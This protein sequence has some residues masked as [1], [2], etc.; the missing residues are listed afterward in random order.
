LATKASFG[1]A[2]RSRGLCA[3]H[4]FIAGLILAS[5]TIPGGGSGAA[6]LK[7]VGSGEAAGQDDPIPAK[8]IVRQDGLGDQK[9]LL[10]MMKGPAA[11]I[12]VDLDR[13]QRLRSIAG[14]MGA[15]GGDMRGFVGGTGTASLFGF[16]DLTVNYAADEDGG[17]AV[18]TRFS[19]PIDDFR[20]TFSH[21]FNRD[22]ESSWTGSGDHRAKRIYEGWVDWAGLPELPLGLGIR[23]TSHADGSYSID[24]RAMQTIPI[25]ATGGSF[26]NTIS[27][28][29]LQDQSSITN[30]TL[31]YY[32]PI[33]GVYASAE[34]DYT[35]DKG[36]DVTAARF[37]I[38]KTFEDGWTLFMY[39]NQPL[40]VGVGRLDFGATRDLGGFTVS[41]SASAG[42]DGS[43]Y[44]GL[45]LTMPLSPQG[46]DTRWLGF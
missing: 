10:S 25:A 14:A 45:K 11:L 28:G 46:K 30:G 34:L 3:V 23:Q 16:G 5:L 13:H 18:E 40:P 17:V 15:S 6:E 21:T 31:M 36:F 7:W 37:G 44:V 42:T 24:L 32:G 38:D 20:F 22:F 19:K 41:A 39:G 9:G 12:D 29:L 1:A 8:L 26:A 43:G 4:I 35:I 2:P 27:T 33:G